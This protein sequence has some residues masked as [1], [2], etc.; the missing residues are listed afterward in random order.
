MLEHFLN[1]LSE[2]GKTKIKNGT[3]SKQISKPLRI[4]CH[5]AEEPT[6][7][8]QN[9]IKIEDFFIILRYCIK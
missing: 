7:K 9:Q 2:T 5:E 4:K 8:N 3:F 1:I 6:Y